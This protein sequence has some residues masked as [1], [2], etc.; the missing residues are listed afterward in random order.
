MQMMSPLKIHWHVITVG[1]PRRVVFF[2]THLSC[3]SVVFNIL[4]RIRGRS[5][6]TS[7]CL[8]KLYA[9]RPR[10]PARVEIAESTSAYPDLVSGTQAEGLLSALVSFVQPIISA[11]VPGSRKISGPMLVFILMLS[12]SL[13]PEYL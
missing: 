11:S 5:P 12:S 6:M 2:I 1:I 10:K 8:F 3:F 9:P 13:D 7:K 4:N